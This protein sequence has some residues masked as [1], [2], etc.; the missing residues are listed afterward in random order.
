MLPATHRRGFTLIELLV[1][2]AII[3]VLI[4]LLLP[5]VQKVR[6]AANRAKC[7]NNLKQLGLAFINFHEAQGG[8]PPS[9]IADNWPTWA[10]FVLPFIEQEN[11]Y[12]NWDMNLRYF[13]QPASAGVDPSMFH[14][15]SRSFPG[16]FGTAGE[17]RAFSAAMGG[18]GGTF[19]G[20]GG[21]SDYA[22]GCGSNNTVLPRPNLQLGVGIRAINPWTGDYCNP[23]QV[24]AYENG[25]WAP[26]VRTNP[27]RSWKSFLLARKMVHLTDGTSATL[28]LGEKYI[29]PRAD[30][31]VASGGVVFNGDIQSQYLRFAGYSGTQ[32]PVTGRWTREYGLV[33]DPKY[34]ASDWNTRFSATHHQGIGQFVLADGSVRGVAA[35]VPLAVL[36]SL[37]LINDGLV[38][39]E[40]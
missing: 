22:I 36:H 35:S 32:D 15:P 28:M 9:E 4:G 10:A 19:T 34:A 13:V 6:E 21:F 20:P 30:G 37:S 40:N 5:A 3:A 38:V 33:T 18:A 25:D 7:Q 2:I 39:N 23:F 31:T 16:Q 17:A 27:S 26:S 12:R 24:D 14:C 1:V 29:A 11:A 8:F